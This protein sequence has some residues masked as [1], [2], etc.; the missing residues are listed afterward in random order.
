MFQGKK[1]IFINPLKIQ[2]Y[3][4]LVKIFNQQHG[5]PYKPSPT[6]VYPPV[7]HSS[8]DPK[9]PKKKTL[10]SAGRIGQESSIGLRYS[11]CLLDPGH[12]IQ[13]HPQKP[14]E[15]NPRVGRPETIDT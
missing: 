1:N 14:P 6:K 3:Y 2:F 9:L 4:L 12:F 15:P 7:Y 8:P 5:L 13:S 10:F 11:H